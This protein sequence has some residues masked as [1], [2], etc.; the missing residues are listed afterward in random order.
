MCQHLMV[1]LTILTGAKTCKTDSASISKYVGGIKFSNLEN[2]LVN[3]V[4][5][6]EAEQY[7]GEDIDQKCVLHIPQFLDTEA[8]KWFNR[9][10]SHVQ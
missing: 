8:K 10:I 5:M 1:C 9:H 7:G 6:F 2:W 3:L 4:V